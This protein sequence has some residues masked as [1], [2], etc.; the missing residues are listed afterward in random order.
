MRGSSARARPTVE[1][2]TPRLSATCRAV[3]HAG[4]GRGHLQI[5][6]AGRRRQG[7]PAGEAS[8]AGKLLLD[9]QELVPLR[10]ALR[11]AE[12]ADLELPGIPAHGEMGD[13]NVLG[14]ARARRD[15][16][17]EAGCLARF[18]RGARAGHGAGLVRLDQHGVE[19]LV[20]RSLFDASRMGDEIVV[21]DDLAAPARAAVKALKPCASSS[22]SGSSIETIG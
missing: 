18:Q 14:L 22:A 20:A 15:D 16:G 9:A 13:G 11:A 5:T 4:G 17:P 3:S 6:S 2:A 1:T 8:L 7:R 21:A 19:R 10:H 12:G